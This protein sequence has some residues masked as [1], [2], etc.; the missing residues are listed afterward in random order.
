V[1]GPTYYLIIG[2]A[3]ILRYIREVPASN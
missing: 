2:R 3:R 1:V